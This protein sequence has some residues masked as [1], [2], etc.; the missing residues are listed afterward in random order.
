MIAPREKTEEDRYAGLLALL[1]STAKAAERIAKADL[2]S[3]EG[4]A[5][6]ESI[7]MADIA[8]R[9]ALNEPQPERGTRP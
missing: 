9:L 4:K 2:R 5:I 6:L 3:T 1:D 7:R 8:L